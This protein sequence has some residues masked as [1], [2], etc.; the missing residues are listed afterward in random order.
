MKSVDRLQDRCSARLGE[1]AVGSEHLTGTGFQLGKRN[2]LKLEV[3]D[4][5]RD[6]KISAMKPDVLSL[7]PRDPY[8][9]KGALPPQVDQIS[10]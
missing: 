9:R 6:W 1:A 8:S 7:I 2:I 10:T 5:P 3:C 4:N